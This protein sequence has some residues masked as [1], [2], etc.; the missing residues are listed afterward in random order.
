MASFVTR[1]ATSAAR[2]AVRNT[3][4]NAPAFTRSATRSLSIL[5]RASQPA[6]RT[7]VSFQ[8]CYQPKVKNESH[9]LTVDIY[10]PQFYVDNVSCDNTRRAV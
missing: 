1:S 7:A 2:A 8:V 3:P 5:A 4:R 9:P 10:L 6:K